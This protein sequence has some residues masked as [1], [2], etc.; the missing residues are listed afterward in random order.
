MK[1]LAG[2]SHVW[3]LL[4]N[5]NRIRSA[6]WVKTR[7]QQP[8]QRRR[9]TRLSGRNQTSHRSAENCYQHVKLVT[10]GSWRRRRH[11]Q[12]W[13]FCIRLSSSPQQ[14]LEFVEK[15]Q[16]FQLS[17]GRDR[18]MI[19]S[20][21]LIP[22][23]PHTLKAHAAQTQS[24]QTCHQPFCWNAFSSLH[25]A[26]QIKTHIFLHIRSDTYVSLTMHWWRK[27]KLPTK[28]MFYCI[29]QLIAWRGSWKKWTEM[30]ILLV[31]K[32]RFY[33]PINDN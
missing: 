17:A 1:L 20:P 23:H 13:L 33:N 11:Q 10:D 25:K 3:L 2:L 32:K 27:V 16:T 14:E 12:K 28:V 8:W 9:N 24:E 30:V 18:Y 4:Q 19:Y 7:E 26:F 21:S 31:W 22:A 15:R 29:L 5:T 6:V